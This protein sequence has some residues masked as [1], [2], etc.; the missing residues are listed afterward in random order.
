[1]RQAHAELTP[2]TPAVAARLDRAAVELDERTDERQPDA[3]ADGPSLDRRAVHLREHL[4]NRVLH[5]RWDADARVRHGDEE[6]LTA[7]L[8]GQPDAAAGRRELRRVIEEIRQDL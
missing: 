4:E 1:D 2:E 3:E 8:R 7:H 6:L 5:T